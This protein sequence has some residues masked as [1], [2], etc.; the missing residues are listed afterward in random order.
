MCKYAFPCYDKDA[1]NVNVY[2]RDMIKTKIKLTTFEYNF[3]SLNTQNVYKYIECAYTK[4]TKFVLNS[5]TIH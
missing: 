1:I 4:Y 5:Y 2:Y 3:P